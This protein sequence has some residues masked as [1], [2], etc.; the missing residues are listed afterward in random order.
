MRTYT[1]L[2]EANTA[3]LAQGLDLITRLDDCVYAEEFGIRGVAF[4]VPTSETTSPTPNPERRTP[5]AVLKV[6]PHFR[7][8]IDFY[9]CFLRGLPT[10]AIDYDWRGRDVTIEKNR[11]AVV[12]SIEE[13][14][15]SLRRLTVVDG[16]RAVQV[17]A[18]GTADEAERLNWSQSSVR[19]EL[20]FLL[21][22]TVHHYALIALALR[23]QGVEPGRE[24]GIAP[25]TLTHWR[26]TA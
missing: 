26:K 17:R 7:H 10:G 12:S 22:H 20:Q 6:G 14:I 19:R 9:R 5:N 4:G 2:I 25:S 16:L 15:A 18:E 11:V 1:P 13:I 3:V 24:F 21:S 8:C 23:L